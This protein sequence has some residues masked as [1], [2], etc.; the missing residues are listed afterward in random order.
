MTEI[1]AEKIPTI[2]AHVTEVVVHVHSLDK[3]GKGRDGDEGQKSHQ[4]RSPPSAHT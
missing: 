3:G 1:A 4:R 2:S